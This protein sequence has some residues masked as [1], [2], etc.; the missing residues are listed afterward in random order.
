VW[1]GRNEQVVKGG[2]V[3]MRGGGGG[4]EGVEAKDNEAESGGDGRV[5]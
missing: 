2:A 5:L 3:G 4:V 1:G